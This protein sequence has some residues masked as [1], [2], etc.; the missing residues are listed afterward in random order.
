M[1]KQRPRLEPIQ[2]ESEHEDEAE[3]DKTGKQ[4]DDHQ[5]QVSMETDTTEERKATDEEEDFQ[6]QINMETEEDDDAPLRVL[7]PR[8]FSCSS[9][10]ESFSQMQST[11]NDQEQMENSSVLDLSTFAETLCDVAM[12]PGKPRIEFQKGSSGGHQRIKVSIF[13][14]F[15]LK[16]KIERR[17]EVMLLLF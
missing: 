14:H 3:L 11:N 16:L 15:I 8:R 12:P 4:E 13:S 10:S 2:E 9:N 17:E 7:R 6:V 1:M 5:F